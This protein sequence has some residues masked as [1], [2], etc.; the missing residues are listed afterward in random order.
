MPAIWKYSESIAD[1]FDYSSSEIV[2]S[3]IFMLIMNTLNSFI[4]LP[5][6]VYSIFVIEEK[7][8]FNKQVNNRI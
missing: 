6:H 8:G 2:V 7:H 5:F 4:S 1:K 3:I